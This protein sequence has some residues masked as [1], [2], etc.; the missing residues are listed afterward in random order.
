LQ[1][2]QHPKVGVFLQLRAAA[3]GGRGHVGGMDP[4]SGPGMTGRQA[5]YRNARAVL[6]RCKWVF[7]EVLA[8][9]GRNDCSKTDNSSCCMRV[10]CAALHVFCHLPCRRLVFVGAHPCG[11]LPFMCI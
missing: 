1:H 11:R 8:R 3:G 6:Q 10:W 4:G 2:A 9:G 7:S 5:G